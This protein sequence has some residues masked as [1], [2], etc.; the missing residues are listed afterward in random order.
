[1]RKT[2]TFI[3]LILVNSIAL[4]Q[5]LVSEKDKKIFQSANEKYNSISE[6][7]STSLDILKSALENYT[8]ILD[9]FPKSK[10]RF[11]SLL[12]KAMIEY[13]LKD[14]SNSK[15]TFKLLLDSSEI[16]S[17]SG[18]NFYNEEYYK[19]TSAY[20]LALISIEENDFST[21]I[22]YFD[23]SKKYKIRFGCGFAENVYNNHIEELYKICNEKITK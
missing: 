14:Y 20:R 19:N 5:D 3:I 21:A 7:D 6:K 16:K 4:S 9:S 1:M 22:Q 13:K 11:E 10:Y 12:Q 2:I 15:K 8:I 17:Y 23:I 18:N